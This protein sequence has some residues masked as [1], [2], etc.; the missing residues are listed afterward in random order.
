VELVDLLQNLYLK[1]LKVHSKIPR[2][3]IRDIIVYHTSD[4]F[5]EYIDTK[6]RSVYV[7]S[8]TFA[9]YSP[10][11][12]AEYAI[13]NEYNKSIVSVQKTDT[14]INKEIYMNMAKQFGEVH[15]MLGNNKL[16][17]DADFVEYLKGVLDEYPSCQPDGIHLDIEPHTFPEWKTNKQETVNQYLEMVGKAS[18]FC[19][20]QKLEL[21]VSIPLH[22]GKEVIDKLFVLC[23]H[24]Y[25]MCYENIDTDYILKKVVPFVD[26]SKDQITLAFR[27]E[28]FANRIEMEEKINLIESKTE[29]KSYAYH[30]LRRMIEWD[31]HAIRK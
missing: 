2:S 26:N 24:V 31:R 5:N 15:F 4:D 19:R 25:F 17:Y 13:Y 9:D 29:L 23:D 28:D 22:Y 30:D 8:S 1:A 21:A 7:W 10:E 6:N 11:F 12:M 16:F 18:T 20:E 14:I 3:D 27:Q